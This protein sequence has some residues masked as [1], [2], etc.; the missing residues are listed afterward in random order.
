M[1]ESPTTPQV[2]PYIYRWNRM[3]RKGQPC[4]VLVRGKMNSCLVMFEDGFTAATS[5]R[6][7][8]SKNWRGIMVIEDQESISAWT[9][10]TFGPASSNARVAAR[11]NEGMAEPLRALIADHN[12]AKTAEKV[13][14]V[15]IV[16]CRLMT[17]DG[18]QSRRR[19]GAQDGDQSHTARESHGRRHGYHGRDKITPSGR[20]E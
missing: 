6:A 10:Q 8:A 20:P 3:G 11:A 2:F 13:A 9:D 7:A 12:H 15:V 1:Q 5:Q 4:A 19:A 18:P 14:N 16:L 17:Q